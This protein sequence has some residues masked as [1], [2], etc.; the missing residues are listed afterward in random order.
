MISSTSNEMPSLMVHTP[1]SLEVSSN[2]FSTHQESDVSRPT[3]VAKIPIA[4]PWTDT[5]DNGPHTDPEDEEIDVMEVT[6]PNSVQNEPKI[7]KPSTVETQSD[8]VDD[9]ETSSGCDLAESDLSDAGKGK[10]KKKWNKQKYNVAWRW[11][12]LQLQSAELQH[13]LKQC[14]ASVSLPQI[15]AN[16]SAPTSTNDA[17]IQPTPTTTTQSLPSSPIL[18]KTNKKQPQS[19]H[20]LFPTKDEKKRSAPSLD[21]NVERHKRLKQ[22]DADSSRKLLSRSTSSL[23]TPTSTESPLNSPRFKRSRSSDKFNIDHMV[24]PY[25]V[26]SP[27]PPS[28][29]KDVPTPKWRDFGND[30]FEG[31]MARSQSMESTSPCI[32]PSFR[33][34][35][36]TSEVNLARSLSL[37]FPNEDTQDTSKTII[38]QQTDISTDVKHETIDSSTGSRS[39]QNGLE[40]A[41]SLT[42]TTTFSLTQEGVDGNQKREFH[43][44]R[45]ES[46]SSLASQTGYKSD[47]SS[48]EEDTSDEAFMLR[49]FCR[50]LLERRRLFKANEHCE[51]LKCPNDLDQLSTM[52]WQ[53][54]EEY[55]KTKP[56]CRQ[57]ELRAKL[58]E[59][60]N[61][62]KHRYTN[63]TQQMLRWEEQ[64]IAAQQIME[65]RARE[66]KQREAYL[67]S[68]MHR[69]HREPRVRIIDDEEDEEEEV[70]QNSY[71]ASSE[72]EEDFFDQ[73]S[74]SSDGSGSQGLSDESEG[75]FEFDDDSDGEYTR[76]RRRYDLTASGRR[77]GRHKKRK[78]MKQAQK[79]RRGRPKQLHQFSPEFGRWEIVRKTPPVDPITNQ[80]RNIIYLRR[81][82]EHSLSA[83]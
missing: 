11:S 64:G 27:I 76:Y 2:Q 16:S 42:A 31:Y 45:S 28:T 63:P 57:Q 24:L 50:E 71:C 1:S 3:T 53:S 34:T 5:N 23:L 35:K 6:P 20:P 39:N 30:P 78:K 40:A 10:L 62:I 41:L 66:M 68:A 9:T 51:G 60:F 32:S 54:P 12:W 4:N 83:D 18:P 8:K 44:L 22:Y 46:S 79:A 21:L 37:E 75:V 7:V 56:R 17:T 82:R 13:Q 25:T 47:G 80:L 65:E 15:T 48:S 14:D 33:R 77:K 67:A 73:Y 26:V 74:E 72:E 52:F 29:P 81:V 59:K 43:L 19:R 70:E 55:F 38:Y 61:R 49:H 69:E 58:K 36:S